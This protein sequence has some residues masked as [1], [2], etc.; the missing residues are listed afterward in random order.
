MKRLLFSLFLSFSL[1]SLKAQQT[2]SIGDI[3]TKT[4]AVLYLKGNGSQGLII[5][6]I[7][8]TGTF[9]EKGMIAFNNTDNKVYYHDGASWITVGAGGGSGTAQ[10]ISIT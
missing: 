1:L 5:P 6:I 2:V 10:T 9:G 4:N 3:Q 8:S 7:N